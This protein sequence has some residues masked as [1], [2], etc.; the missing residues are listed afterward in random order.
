M[1]NYHFVA[2]FFFFFFYFFF[3]VHPFM[4]LPA[5][6]SDHSKRTVARAVHSEWQNIRVDI[7]GIIIKI[8]VIFS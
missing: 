4:P 8:T 1:L 3:L 5:C 7:I 6:P 2:A